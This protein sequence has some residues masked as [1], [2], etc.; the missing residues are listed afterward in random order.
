MNHV[1]LRR[2]IVGSLL[3]WV[4]CTVMLMTHPVPQ[5]QRVGAQEAPTA[6]ATA[7]GVP[8][9]LARPVYL[10]LIQRGQGT[11]PTPEPVPLPDS[12]AT[13][14]YAR[15]NWD[16]FGNYD[17]DGE[18]RFVQLAYK[19]GYD[20]VQ[21][22]P[23]SNIIL[24]FG[25]Q[26][27]EGRITEGGQIIE[28]WSVLLPPNPTIEDRADYEELQ[29]K[30]RDWVI[31]IAESFIRGYTDNPD[32]GFTTIAIG[33][34]NLNY[35][36]ACDNNGLI[37]PL[38]NRAGQEW[39]NMIEE[40]RV[41]GNK[42]SLAGA[43]DIEP[44]DEVDGPGGWVAC[45]LGAIF[46]IDGYELALPIDSSDR[47][48]LSDNMLNFGNNGWAVYGDPQWT[49]FQVFRVFMGEDIIRGHPQIYCPG[50]IDNDDERDWVTIVERFAGPSV[51]FDGV[52]SENAGSFVCRISRSLT[53]QQSWED[54][55]QALHTI[56][57]LNA[58]FLKSS[59]SS[60]YLPPRDED[61]P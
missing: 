30:D 45:G 5:Q 16:E 9:Q 60:F 48:Y 23:E 61:M 6:A 20:A 19:R 18:Q 34:A 56:N 28:E 44:W 29:T 31:A 49:Q 55:Y 17:I 11:A 40:I 33:T 26:L 21:G 10:P 42:V 51:R 1:A 43:N 2:L 54:F 39:R 12:A 15:W 53:W 47:D 3:V 35:D 38:W 14:R 57:G 32:H 8:A 41:P 52:T 22:S 50:N 27:E 7:E 58:S 59:V 36:W 24:G 46:W 25:R 13:A 4:V 37:D